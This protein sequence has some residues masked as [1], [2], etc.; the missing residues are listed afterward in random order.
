VAVRTGKIVTMM[1]LLASVVQVKTGSFIIVMPGARIFTMVAIRLMPDS[2]V[3]TPAIWRP[4][5]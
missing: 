2:V 4:Q 1:A 3:P 5:M